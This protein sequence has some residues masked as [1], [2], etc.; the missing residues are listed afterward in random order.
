MFMYD[1]QDS[2]DD[3]DDSKQSIKT[4]EATQLM[5]GPNQ[6]NFKGKDESWQIIENL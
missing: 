2:W 6:I 3:K 4:L 5:E 1:N